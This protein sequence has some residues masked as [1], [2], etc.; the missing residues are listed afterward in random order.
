MSEV[1]ELIRRVAAVPSFSSYEER[2]HPLIREILADVP[3]AQ[4]EVVPENNLLV[5]IPGTVPGPPIAMAA[6]LD[7]ID[8]YVEGI[9]ALHVDVR[10]GKIV[11]PMDDSAGLGICLAIARQASKHPFPPLLLLLSEM[12]ESFGFER[13]PQRLKNGGFG[14]EPGQGAERLSRRLLATG[15]TPSAVITL[16]TT[17][18]FKGISG[19]ALYCAP[20]ELNGVEASGEL[21]DATAELRDRLLAI[22]P[23][24]LVANNTNDY[25][26][27]GAELNLPGRPP[28][29]SV[30]LEPSIFPYHR[31]NEEVFVEDILRLEQV[32]VT[33]LSGRR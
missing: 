22:D 26:T 10:D 8:H 15:R 9:P 4:I 12:E 31:A 14:R 5:S 23:D 6:H 3:G 19:R 13:H 32:L 18:L 24:L 17:P 20:W 7:K 27:Y 25:L 21:R 1:V 29:P 16:D 33:F 11:G 28:I 30:A 2:L